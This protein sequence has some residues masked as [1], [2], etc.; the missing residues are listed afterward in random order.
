MKLKDKIILITGGSSGIGRASALLLAQEGA[1]LILQAR[2]I[3][4]L[5]STAA[6]I[7][8]LGAQVH[9]YTTDLKSPE[10]I[11]KAADQMIEEVGLPEVIINSAGEGEWLSL[12]EASL[13]HFKKTIESPYLATAYTCKVFYDRMEVRAQ[14]HFIIINS[15]ASYFSF[16]GVTGYAAARWA[17]LGFAKALQADL[18][19]SHFKVSLVSFGK[20]DSPYFT[21]NPVSENR[22]PKISDWLV[23][24]L[25]VEDAAK[26]ILKTVK[27][28][29]NTTIRPT[30][31]NVL[32][33]MYP[34]FPKMFS[35]LMRKTGHHAN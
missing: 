4:K 5:K 29:K 21:N 25:S 20:V 19:Q 17:L 9:Y 23:P 7:E 24:T 27:S 14:G 13:A 16:P 15:A 22:I 2:S 1:I 11:E 26:V 33:K 32:V 18:F 34:F 31:M 28:P 6:E 12:K 10:A 8:A 3:D 35:Y 30:M